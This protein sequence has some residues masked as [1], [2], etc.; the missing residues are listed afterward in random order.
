MKQI[1]DHFFV[2]IGEFFPDIFP[3]RLFCPNPT[4]GY[5]F[6]DSW[7]AHRFHRS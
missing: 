4:M 1:G 7:D 5:E 3:Q 6:S 2:A